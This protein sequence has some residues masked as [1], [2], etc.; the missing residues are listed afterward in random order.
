MTANLAEAAEFDAAPP[1]PDEELFAATELLQQL[2]RIDTSNPPGNEKEAIRLLESEAAE[3]G[4]ATEID[5]RHGDRPNLVAKWSANPA[6]CTNRPLII[7]CH[8]D[9]VPADAARW[10]HP[11]FAGHLEDDH[12]WGRGAIDM[13]GFAVMGFAALT[14]LF[15]ESLPINRD[16]LFV[17]VSDEEAGTRYGSEWLVENRPDLLGSKPEYVIN[18]VGGFTIHQAG[19]RF[20]PIQIAEKGVAW[21][22]LTLD[23]SPGHS[24]MPASNSSV[25][26]LANAVSAISAAQ[27]PWHPGPEAEAYIRGFAD[28]TGWL[29]RKVVGGVFHPRH[30]P[31]LLKWA[32]PSESRRGSLEA[33]LRNTATP[34]CLRSGESINMIPSRASVDID[35]RLVPGQSAYDLIAELREVLPP[36]LREVSQFE[37]LH[38]SPA[39]TFS[40]ETRL[41]REIEATIHQADPGAIPL[42]S[43]IPGFTDSRNYAKLGADCYGFY[44]VKLPPELDFATM[45]HGDDERIPVEGFHWGIKT[46]TELLRRFLVS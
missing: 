15:R 27:L 6:N 37:I 1:F 32:V 5:G 13:K 11:P 26:R 22:R 36:D 29:A 35:G 38:E 28:P 25:E 44:P 18:E 30:G 45:F 41:Y 24:S 9:V 3:L 19:F 21:L 7:S 46:L 2:L 12:L 39:V 42:P 20:Y 33:I 17:A 16:V 14:R 4:L 23:G 34:T 10:T 40:K 8:I 31:R 43:I